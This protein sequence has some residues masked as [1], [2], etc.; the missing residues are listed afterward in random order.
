MK[1]EKKKKL[2][3]QME[4]KCVVIYGGDVEGQG[5]CLFVR[6]NEGLELCD[7]RHF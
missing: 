2:T 7:V 3:P 5:F 6:K 1:K 4:C